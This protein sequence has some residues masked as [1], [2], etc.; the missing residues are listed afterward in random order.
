MAPLEDCL[1]EGYQD[2]MQQPAQNEQWIRKHI[3]ANSK[4]KLINVKKD[5]LLAR[6]SILESGAQDL[7]GRATRTQALEQRIHPIQQVLSEAQSLW[8]AAHDYLGTVQVLNC[9]MNRPLEPNMSAT[10][11]AD[12]VAKAKAAVSKKNMEVPPALM[13]LLDNVRVPGP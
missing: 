1:P 7:G 4:H 12:H 13:E 5:Q 10:E 6:T 8:K 11:L 9:I 2:K 3:F